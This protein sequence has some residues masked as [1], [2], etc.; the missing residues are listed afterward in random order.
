[1]I[2]SQ[3]KPFEEILGYLDGEKKVFIVGCKG[4]AEVCHTGDESQVLEMKG[5]LERE[6]KTVTGY[7]VIDFL[8]DKALI[9]TRLYLH[10]PEIDAADSLLV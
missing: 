1:M 7:C 5:K 10:E 4:C 3:L 8:C 2:I 9:K 6:G